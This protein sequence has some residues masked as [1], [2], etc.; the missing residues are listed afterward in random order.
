MEEFTDKD[1]RRQKYDRRKKKHKKNRNE[2]QE[3]G[4]YNLEEDWLAEE[5]SEVDNAHE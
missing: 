5:E 1:I 2:Y 4:P 3:C